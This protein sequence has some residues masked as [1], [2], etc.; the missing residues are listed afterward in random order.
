LKESLIVIVVILLFLLFSGNFT[1][2]FQAIE[3][4]FVGFFPIF[5]EVGKMAVEEYIKSPY[6][7]TG[8]IMAIAS[9]FGIWFSAKGG[10][11]LW[12]IVSIVC[13][14]ASLASILNN[15]L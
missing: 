12:I 6:F 2:F 14:L 11:V 5:S 1:A 7:I 4:L 13:E 9:A 10:K 8:V 3:T 15:L